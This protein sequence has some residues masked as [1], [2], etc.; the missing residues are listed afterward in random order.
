MRTKAAPTTQAMIIP[1]H[2]KRAGEYVMNVSV[3]LGPLLKDALLV[4]RTDES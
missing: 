4:V 2:G 3:F 1:R